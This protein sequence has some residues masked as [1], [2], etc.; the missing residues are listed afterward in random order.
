MSTERLAV[1]G[2]ALR[3][4]GFHLS[5]ID[6]SAESGEYIALKAGSTSS[7]SARPGR[8]RRSSSRRSPASAG[9]PAGGS[10]STATI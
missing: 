4:G 9:R 5:G 1:R 8:G 10:S 7:S 3:A 2:L 6:L